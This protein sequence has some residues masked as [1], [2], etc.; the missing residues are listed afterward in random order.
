[1]NIESRFLLVTLFATA[2]LVLPAS[3]APGDTD[4]DGVP[5]AN[6]NCTLVANADQ[7]DADNDGYGNA[8]DGDLD[9]SGRVTTADHTILRNALNTTN[10]A[11]DLNHDGSVNAADLAM[12][13]SM[14]NRPPGPSGLRP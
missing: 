3:A 9:G 11:A 8:C 14:L 10:A 7:F 5:D 2:L 12:L 4:G 13:E 1:M 6:D